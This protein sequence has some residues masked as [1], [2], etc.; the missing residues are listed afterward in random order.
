MRFLY[1]CPH[2]FGCLLLTSVTTGGYKYLLAPLLCPSHVLRHSEVGKRSVRSVIRGKKSSRSRQ[3]GGCGGKVTS[4]KRR[5]H[6][7]GS[8]LTRADEEGKE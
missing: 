1:V 6:R 4:V 5:M 7:P 8:S 3:V 2:I